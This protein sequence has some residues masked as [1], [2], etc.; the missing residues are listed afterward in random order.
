MAAGLFNA[1]AQRRRGF[2]GGAARVF[3]HETHEIHEKEAWF[4]MKF[5]VFH[6]SGLFNAETHAELFAVD[7]RLDLVVEKQDVRHIIVHAMDFRDAA[8][9]HRRA[10]RRIARIEQQNGL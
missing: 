1:E 2:L 9:A 5:H 8:L 7:D 10:D 4:F 3:Y 6:G